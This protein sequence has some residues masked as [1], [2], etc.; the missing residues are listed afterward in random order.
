MAEASPAD[1]GAEYRPVSP[2]AVAA[3]VAGCSAALA[4]VT[5]FAWGLPLLGT[6][7]AAAALADVGRPDARKAGRLAALA[8]LALSVGF[9]AQAVTAVLADQWIMAGRARAAATAWID[10]VREGR[11]AEALS[12]CAATV[13][14]ASTLPPDLDHEDTDAERLRRFTDLAAVKAVAGCGTTRPAVAG[15]VAAGTD[16]GGWIVRADLAGCGAAGSTARIIVV[17][18][19][20]RRAAGSLEQWRIAVVDLDR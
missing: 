13:L 15:P 6:L 7:L 8:G 9:G 4:L 2:L 3:L 14:P 11:A 10:A 1:P 18:K 17:P 5:R 16:D 12:L 20:V 19:R